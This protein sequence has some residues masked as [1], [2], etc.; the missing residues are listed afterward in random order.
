MRG[1]LTSIHDCPRRVSGYR[2][3]MESKS[4][5]SEP[6]PAERGAPTR[7]KEIGGK[8]FRVGTGDTYV[9]FR[10]RT[11]RRRRAATAAVLG[12]LVLGAGLYG[13]VSLVSPPAAAPTAAPCPTVKAAGAALPKPA[14]VTVNVYNASTRNGLAASTAAALKLRGFTIGKVTNDPLKSNLTGAA[15]VRGG[16]AGTSEMRV[17]AAEVT[18]AKLQPDSRTD[19]SVD[20]VL[21]A[22]FSALTSPEQ[23]TAALRPSAEASAHAGCAAGR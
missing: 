14:E 15:Q 23:A 5:G 20:L 8:K 7:R 2:R 1:Y 18:G 4:S 10:S 22:G 17:V 13:V 21:G 16:K 12:L 19:D 9:P 6:G 3:G 11:R